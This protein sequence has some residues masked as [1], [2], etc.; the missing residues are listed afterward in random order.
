MVKSFTTRRIITISNFESLLFMTLCLNLN[1]SNG[2]IDKY[3]R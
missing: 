2:R 3:Q 1:T